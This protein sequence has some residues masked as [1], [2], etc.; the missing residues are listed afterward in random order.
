LLPPKPP[1][2]D[3][4]IDADLIAGMLRGETAAV[5]LLIGRHGR[6]VASVAARYLGNAADAEDVVQDTFLRVWQQAARFDPARGK[7][8]SWIYAIAVRLCLDRLRRQ[9]VRRIF[10]LGRGLDAG[11]L[12]ADPGPG[13]DETLAG[14]EEL[15]LTRQA[16]A[17]LPDRQRLAILLAAVAGLDTAAIAE[18]LD[19]SP[20]A[21][22]QLLVRARR[23]LRAALPR[24]L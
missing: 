6:A 5:G 1:E 4:D 16:L 3:A 13:A 19:I 21:V 2:T 14:R 20:G 17:T 18:A 15:A 22:E 8:V 7:A 23:G 12:V 11:E 10:G 24:A 9:K